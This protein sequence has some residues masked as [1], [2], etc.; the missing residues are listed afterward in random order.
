[1]PTPSGGLSE[2]DPTDAA[3]LLESL[4]ARGIRP[5]LDTIRALL[6]ALD[7]PQRTLPVV[8]V[9]GT[10]GKGSTTA[11]LT[12]MLCAAGY[13][14]GRY[15]SPPLGHCSEQITIDAQPATRSTLASRL[16]HV[17]ALAEREKPGIVTA[18][19]AMTAVAIQTFAAADVDLAVLEV[20][21]G[22]SEDATNATDPMLSVITTVALDHQ[23]W[24][25]ASLEE[26]ARTKAGVLRT[27]RPAVIGWL[28]DAEATVRTE[29]TLRGANCRFAREATGEWQ[30]T[31]R[32]LDGQIVQFMTRRARHTLETR[33]GG[34]HQARNL[35]VA[36][37]AAEALNELG[38]HRLTRAAIEDGARACRWPGRMEVIES[39][40]GRTILLDGAHNVAGARALEKFLRGLDRPFDLI[41]GALG[42]KDI[43]AMLEHLAPA[44]R[45]VWLVPVAHRRSWDPE[46]YRATLDAPASMRTTVTDLTAALMQAANPETG[47]LLVVC[48]SLYLVGQARATVLADLPPEEH[49]A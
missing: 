24:L 2:V 30:R 46:A 25:G 1:M 10:N 49:H 38:F 33:L 15:T 5:G 18:F 17:L 6:A 20:G 43:E 36:T 26:I 47:A 42:D 44:A 11:F 28:G 19:E 3:A 14:T 34:R 4:S 9:G 13:R 27:G 12:A 31:D 7:S 35:A 29:A 16:A 48:G 37:L 22:G 40:L 32:G 39:A 21:M 45:R 8:L 23:Q 41:F